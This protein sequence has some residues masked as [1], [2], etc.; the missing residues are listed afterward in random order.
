MAQHVMVQFRRLSAHDHALRL[1][2]ALLE[3]RKPL[4]ITAA[5]RA[6][7]DDYIVS[8]GVLLS[9]ISATVRLEFFITEEMEWNFTMPLMNWVRPACNSILTF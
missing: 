3:L 7:L 4:P 8:E 9:E 5:G 2:D 1:R 6:L